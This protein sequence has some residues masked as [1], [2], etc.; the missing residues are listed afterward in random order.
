MAPA[1]PKLVASEADAALAVPKPAPPVQAAAP[2]RLEPALVKAA[3]KGAF[4]AP[5]FPAAASF[6]A[7]AG[8]G[9]VSSELR[10]ARAQP[11]FHEQQTQHRCSQLERDPLP[12]RD[13]SNAPLV[14]KSA[15]AQSF[16]VALEFV[17]AARSLVSMPDS[18]PEDQPEPEL[19]FA[20]AQD[21]H[22]SLAV[23]EFHFV[24][25]RDFL[26][27]PAARERAAVLDR[28]TPRSKVFFVG[29][30]AGPLPSPGSSVYAKA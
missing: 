14:S 20:P 17:V 30:R 26:E 23:R 21:L 9:S 6:A 24:P 2:S 27:S 29:F 13:C 28:A 11:A 16:S 4:E 25:A 8:A 15:A 12:A 5:N 1:L 10:F 19:Y 18:V 3:L 22:E 7:D